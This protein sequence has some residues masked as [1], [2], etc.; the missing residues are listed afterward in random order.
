LER[1]SRTELTTIAKYVLVAA[2][3]ASSNP[4]KT[5]ARL[6]GRT[7]DERR[8]RRRGRPRKTV[9]SGIGTV[10]QRLLGPAAFPLDR[11]IA[12]IGSLMEEHDENGPTLGASLGDDDQ[13]TEKDTELAVGGVEV[14]ATI[15]ELVTMRLLHRTTPID[16]LDGP[17]SFKCGITQ[18]RAFELAR[19]LDISTLADLMWDPD[20]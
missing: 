6:I 14:S 5:D 12:I 7:P 4:P 20:S 13:D 11:L 10:P 17:P 19:E 2:F 8:K 15:S 18:T 16:K 3:L 1:E 9:T